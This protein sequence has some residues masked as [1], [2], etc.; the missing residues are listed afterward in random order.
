MNNHFCSNILNEQ[1][2]KLIQYSTLLGKISYKHFLQPKL[3]YMCRC[4]VSV[5]QMSHILA[6]MF[7]SVY[8]FRMLCLRSR[9]RYD[10]THMG[11]TLIAKRHENTYVYIYVGL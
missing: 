1:L 3:C 9:L 5:A 8:H 7:S 10:Y 6:E 11:R 4:T 2:L